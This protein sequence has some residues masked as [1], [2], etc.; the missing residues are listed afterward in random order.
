ML[1]L[2]STNLAISPEWHCA[3]GSLMIC[4]QAR[5]RKLLPPL[6]LQLRVNHFGLVM[7][8]T[9]SVSVWIR[10]LYDVRYTLQ[11]KKIS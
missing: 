3:N 4:Y 7:S 9:Y 10:M 8:F 11:K 5:L 1:I 2:N 6:M